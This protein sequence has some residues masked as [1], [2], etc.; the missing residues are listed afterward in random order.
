MRILIALT[1]Y[2]PHV[3]GLTIYAE[4]LARALVARGHR[5]TVLTSRFDAHLPARETLG[6]VEIVRPWVMAR[7]SKGVL[8]PAMGLWATRLAA[9]HDALSIHLPQF[10]APGLAARGRALRRPT[11]LTYH[12]DLSLPPT[13]F[14]RVANQ[15]VHL[16][17]HLAARA[18][19]RIVAYTRDYAEHS[20]FLSRY[21]KKVQVIPPPVEVVRAAPAEVEAFRMRYGLAG[22]T[23]VGMASRLATEKGVEYLLAALPA[24][25]KAFPDL[26][27]LFA[28]QYQNVLGEQS[29]A[30]R[31]AP[32]ISAL[33]DR[34]RFLGTL[35][36]REMSAFFKACAVTVLPSINS[37]ESFGLV[38]I[39][40]M[41]CGTPVVASGLP[42]VRQPVLLTHMGQVVPVGAPT[43]LARALIEVL[44]SPKQYA[45]PAID[46]AATFSPAAVAEAY[47]KLFAE[48]STARGAPAGRGL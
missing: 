26:T 10:D 42:G 6:G 22:R 5:V 28:G 38:Q 39:E 48:I 12:C 37:T 46:L 30:R 8:M 32:L 11:I 33:G 15:A 27:V 17:N 3:S 23:I 16:A 35:D 2:R 40:S 7:L 44:R 13:S 20:P 14:N 29:Y 41:M 31:L 34:W 24:V 19:D 47:E 25:M 9:S 1:Y 36:P 43:D 4:R 18:A 45:Q 21:L